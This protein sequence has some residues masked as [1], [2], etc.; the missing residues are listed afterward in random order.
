MSRSARIA[1]DFAGE[2]TAFRLGVSE[3]EELQEATDQGPL[4]FLHGLENGIWRT[5]HVRDVI[6][7]GLIG[8]GSRPKEAAAFVRQHVE[9]Q[10]EPITLDF[11]D[12]EY[13][14]LLT[15]STLQALEDAR[16]C[17]AFMIYT[18]LSHGS[19][20]TQDVREVLRSALIG[21]G[22][23]PEKTD[24][25]IRFYV[26][27]RPAWEENAKIAAAVIISALKDGYLTASLA[28][29]DI[30]RAAIVEVQD[31]PVPKSEARSRKTATRSRAENG[32]SGSITKSAP[33]SA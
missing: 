22:L 16:D 9:K 4:V 2:E 18:K 27:A 25:L 19:W 8:A 10:A 20:K 28:A 29:A 17:G 15:P 5:R 23:P 14:F 21:G 33:P 3:L 31:D 32:A 26:D 1:L 11:G 30:V 24:H 7:L 6:R 13:P 12:G